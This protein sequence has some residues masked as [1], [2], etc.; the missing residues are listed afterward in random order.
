MSM[1]IHRFFRF[2]TR[3]YHTSF[4]LS[5]KEAS[6]NLVYDAKSIIEKQLQASVQV[7][8]KKIW[9]EKA[10]LEALEG[11]TNLIHL[12]NHT[13]GTPDY[14]PKGTLSKKSD[15]AALKSGKAAAEYVIQN[16]PEYFQDDWDATNVET[17][18][19]N[20]D[21]DLP[22]LE[23][24]AKSKED[25]EEK[26]EKVFSDSVD[27]LNELLKLKKVEKS[28][29]MYLR[30]HKTAVE[31]PTSTVNQLLGLLA[32]ARC[33][34]DDL[35]STKRWPSTIFSTRRNHSKNTKLINDVFETIEEPTP[36]QLFVMM[37]AYASF[38]MSAS[39]FGM[40]HKNVRAQKL[41]LDV[42]T[43]NNLIVTGSYFQ[44]ERQPTMSFLVEMGKSKI[45]PNEDTFS[46]M[47]FA[48]RWYETPEQFIHIWTKVF[49][50][51]AALNIDPGMYVYSRM[52]AAVTKSELN[53][54]QKNELLNYVLD[55]L[56]GKKFKPTTV[57]DYF[58]PTALLDSVRHN[59][60]MTKK[61][62][63][64]IHTGHNLKHFV[65]QSTQNL[66]F[67]RYL[68]T[69]VNFDRIEPAWEAVSTVCHV[70]SLPP[71]MFNEGLLKAVLRDEKPEY[72]PLLC[73]NLTRKKQLEFM[74]V[75]LSAGKKLIHH[76][77]KD[78]ITQLK[79]IA[80]NCMTIANYE[81]NTQQ[82]NESINM[83]LQMVILSG[84]ITALLNAVG[85]VLQN[86][87]SAIIS[88]ET[89][90]LCE[91]FS[92]KEGNAALVEKIRQLRKFYETQDE[93]NTGAKR[94]IYKK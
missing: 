60:E 13:L 10:V 68:E 59:V 37:R 16:H 29:E 26:E 27:S 81:S 20:F 4:L 24:G 58:A 86:Y 6:T 36:D 63:K 66:F 34:T 83:S 15:T 72:I 78:T 90:T 49:N 43:C 39:M 14:W 65:N 52:M 41:V 55:L 28:G 79:H 18:M 38:H 61:L 64:I 77:D 85:M 5:N 88:S 21:E 76:A 33:S 84:D 2:S 57:S 56:E 47:M 74:T 48:L 80:Q 9:H 23:D 50:E 53:S 45:K 22:A 17:W 89:M 70:Y 71:T 73:P 7:P 69:L 1:G 19:K 42:E 67:T 82:F 40:Y 35:K 93:T 54:E 12:P 32:Y 62:Y 87:K 91:E 94:E 75:C 51:M 44:K 25:V 8:K 92:T 11:S 30:L 3:K 46:S 31:V